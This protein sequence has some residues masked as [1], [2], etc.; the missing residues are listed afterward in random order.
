MN[1]K[2]ELGNKGSAEEISKKTLRQEESSRHF[3]KRNR[4]MWP[5][6]SEGDVERIYST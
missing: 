5:K 2:E 1:D 3:R 4:Q 6:N